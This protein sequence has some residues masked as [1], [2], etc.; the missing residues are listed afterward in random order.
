MMTLCLP[1]LYAMFADSRLPAI[2]GAAMNIVRQ[3]RSR[4]QP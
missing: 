4:A 2:A 3:T 1:P